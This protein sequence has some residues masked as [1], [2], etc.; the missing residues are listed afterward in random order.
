M[1]EVTSLLP[2][3]ERIAGPAGLAAITVAASDAANREIFF[4]DLGIFRLAYLANLRVASP[5]RTM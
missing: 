3:A 4:I 5:Q 1:G 2:T